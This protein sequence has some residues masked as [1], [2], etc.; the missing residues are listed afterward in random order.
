MKIFVRAKTG[1]KKEFVKKVDQS[2]FVVSVSSHPIKGKANEAIIE[3]LANYF[4]IPKSKILLDKGLTS[5]EKVI[6]IISSF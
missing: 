5:K 1:A 4:Q 2:H 3:V 6:E